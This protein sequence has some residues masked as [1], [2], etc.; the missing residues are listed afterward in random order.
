MTSPS[1]RLLPLKPECVR[2]L[3]LELE[4]APLETNPQPLPILSNPQ[5][6]K[7]PGP[8][9]LVRDS[10]LLSYTV[11]IRERSLSPKGRKRGGLQRGWEQGSPGPLASLQGTVTGTLN[12]PAG[13]YELD[14]QLGLCLAYQQFHGLRRVV[15]P[16]V[17]LEVCEGPGLVTEGDPF[18][19]LS[20]LYGLVLLCNRSMPLQ[21]DYKNNKCVLGRGGAFVKNDLDESLGQK[22]VKSGALGGAVRSRASPFQKGLPTGAEVQVSSQG[23]AGQEPPGPQKG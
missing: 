1:S 19:S 23:P 21:Q 7:G 18:S 6:K 11:S 9:G 12:Q 4:G 3:E 13:L 16:G 20:Y 14:G 2:E 15:R 22:G 10:R 5:D 17:R 8:D